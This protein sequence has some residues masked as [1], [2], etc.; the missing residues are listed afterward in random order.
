MIGYTTYLVAPLSCNIYKSKKFFVSTA[1]SDDELLVGL[2]TMKAWGIVNKD[3]PKPNINA[4]MNS[5]DTIHLV[6]LRIATIEKT[7]LN[8]SRDIPDKENKFSW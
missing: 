7:I 4:F 2:E 5:E 3:F 6:R 8:K 1:I